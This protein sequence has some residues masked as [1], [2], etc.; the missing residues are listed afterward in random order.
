MSKHDPEKKK[1]AS[2]I[3]GG[4]QA[5]PERHNQLGGVS[6]EVVNRD[7]LGKVSVERHRAKHECVLDFYLRTR[8]ISDPQHQIGMSFRE[9]HI[10]ANNGVNCKILGNSF[11]VDAGHGNYERKMLDH[12]ECLKLLDG[13]CEHLTS[14]QERVLRRVCGYDE[15]AG[16]KAEKKILLRGLDALI[17]HWVIPRRVIP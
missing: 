11:L 2:P 6:T 3:K 14:S 17:K 15:Y 7:A 5:T 16:D 1:Q 12:V 4:E 8:R 13:A 10:R 9:I